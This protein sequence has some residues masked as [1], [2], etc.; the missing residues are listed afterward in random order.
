MKRS[1]IRDSLA[2]MV[3]YRRNFV[4]GGTFFFTVT[5]ADR[6]SSM[7]VDHVGLLRA[8]FRYTR[9]RRPF[10]VDAIVILPDHL[11]AILTLPRGDSDFR[12][13]IDTSAP[14]YCRAQRPGEIGVR[15][16]LSDV[17]EIADQRRPVG[18]IDAAAL[19]P[20]GRRHPARIYL[21]RLAGRSPPA[22]N[23]AAAATRRVV[24]GAE[25]P[26]ARSRRARG[27]RLGP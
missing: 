2:R 13:C 24:V 17:V 20:S 22:G 16:T 7:L 5:L 3:R 9:D 14:A 19:D 15:R 23:A 21:R 1:E 8:A 4:P 26:Q 27:D 6:R 12:H 25:P 10:A 11:H 18:D